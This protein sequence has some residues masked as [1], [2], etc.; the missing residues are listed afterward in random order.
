MEKVGRESQTNL[1]KKV[2]KTST[3][4]IIMTAININDNSAV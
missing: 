2:I 1:T 3:F 4:D